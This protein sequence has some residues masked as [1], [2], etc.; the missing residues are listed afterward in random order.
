[1]IKYK[2]D[3]IS[4]LSELFQVWMGGVPENDY[5][6]RDFLKNSKLEKIIGVSDVDAILRDIAY[7]PE[8]V[9][10]AIHSA[11]PLKLKLYNQEKIVS[12]QELYK[13]NYW[14]EKSETSFC[15]SISFG[16]A[17]EMQMPNLAIKKQQISA[18]EEQ[19][20]QSLRLDKMLL[21]HKK[22]ETKAEIAALEREIKREEKE[23]L[24]KKK[25]EE[26]EYNKVMLKIR[27]KAQ[28]IAN[29]KKQELELKKA[30]ELEQEKKVLRPKRLRNLR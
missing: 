23:A 8:V 11:I 21:Q 15:L 9:L 29:R 7:F 18:L 24:A 4:S 30:E 28:K 25:A 1:M 17:L 6:I 27:A 14:A 12:S 13:L 3:N 22:K 19:R 5:E 26:R 16:A 10:P 2:K 20:K